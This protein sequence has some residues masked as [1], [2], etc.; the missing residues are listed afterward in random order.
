[1]RERL[2]QNN[3]RL[4]L[5]QIEE[6]HTDKW[7]VGL[8]PVKNHQNIQVRLGRA[9]AFLEKYG[10]FEI[11][12]DQFSNDFE[13]RFRAWPDKYY[14]I[15]QSGKVIAKSEYGTDGDNEAKVTFDCADLLESLM[16]K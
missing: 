11:Y 6:A 12:V 4:I 9:H 7:P 15:D 13:K 16:S 1:M 8:E 14:C 5:I 3:I 2:A 10:D